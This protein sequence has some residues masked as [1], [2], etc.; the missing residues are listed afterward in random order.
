M[1][2]SFENSILIPDINLLIGNYCVV[3]EGDKNLSEE[4]LSQMQLNE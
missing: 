2:E 1:N 4:W 3:F